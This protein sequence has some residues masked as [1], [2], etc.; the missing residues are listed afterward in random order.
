MEFICFFCFFLL[1]TS[2]ISLCGWIILHF[3][4]SLFAISKP[5]RGFNSGCDW[6]CVCVCVCVCTSI[7]VL[8]FMY[9]VLCCGCYLRNWANFSRYFLL[10]LSPLDDD[11]TCKITQIVRGRRQDSNCGPPVPKASALTDTLAGPG[12]LFSYY[13]QILIIDF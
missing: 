2:E 12:H 4:M 1:P 8:V 6:I 5:L 9:V 10:L 7:E 13:T 3:S 11:R